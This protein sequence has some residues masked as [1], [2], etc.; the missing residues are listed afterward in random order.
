MK[1]LYGFYF[2]QITKE[3]IDFLL[4]QGYATGINIYLFQQIVK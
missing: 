2:R 3:R 4:V 1:N